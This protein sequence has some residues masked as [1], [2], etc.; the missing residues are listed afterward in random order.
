MTDTVAFGTRGDCYENGYE[1]ALH[2][3]YPTHLDPEQQRCLIGGHNPGCTQPYEAALLNVSAMSYGALSDNAVKALN[4][5][6][7]PHVH[8]HAL[9]GNRGTPCA[10]GPPEVGPRQ[11]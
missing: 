5:G 8:V 11:H 7:C 10:G 2:S 4:T 6:P 3:L 9:R 1:W